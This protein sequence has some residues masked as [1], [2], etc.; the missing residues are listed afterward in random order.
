MRRFALPMLLLPLLVA[1]GED[2]RPAGAAPARKPTAIELVAEE[3]RWVFRPPAGRPD[4]M[5]DRESELQALAARAARAEEQRRRREAGQA[6]EAARGEP[7]D[8]LARLVDWARGEDQRVRLALAGQRYDEAM[9]VADAALKQLEPH[10][11]HA[12]V[13]AVALSL[14]TYRA[15][16][17]EAKLR[18]DAFAAFAALQIRIQGILWSQEGARLAIVEGEPRALAVNDRVRDCTILHIDQDRVDFRFI[19]QRRRFEFPVYV[20]PQLT[21]AAARPPRR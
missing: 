20:D 10:L 1:A 5:V 21:P 17:E 14:R 12:S 4:I 3:E 11:A 16:A 8:D 9:R 7:G 18:D 19:Y 2:Q 6:L 15:Q 13:A